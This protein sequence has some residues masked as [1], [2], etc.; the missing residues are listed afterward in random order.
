MNFFEKKFYRLYVNYLKNRQGNDLKYLQAQYYLKN[1]KKLDLDPPV[2][3]ME[4]IQWLKLY[5]YT[6]QYG[7]YVDKHEVRDFVK[8]KVGEHVLNEEL[9]VYNDVDEI[10]LD[11]LPNQFVL[12][13]THA[14]GYNV[15]VKDKNALDWDKA[16]AD[17]RRWMK[18]N[19]YHKSRERVYKDVQP[20]IVAEKFLNE[21]ADTSIIDYKFYCFHGKPEYV[22]VKLNENGRDYKCY[23]NMDWQKMVPEKENPGFLSREM[24]KPSNFY[25]MVDV[26][27]KLSEG[28]IFMRVDLYS[29]A[30]R[31]LFGEMTFFPTGGI[32]RL[33]VERLNKEMGDLIQLPDVPQ[34]QITQN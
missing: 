21:L 10:N 9:A 13:C 28:F 8:K 4:K 16:K 32:K 19:Y 22:L 2:E 5:K 33:F 7:R 12:K 34:P 17:L 27:K 3:F 25:E 14:S 29:I 24:P 15:I 26:A 23:Y 6:E 30:G 31:T 18:T 1:S 11:E 20:R